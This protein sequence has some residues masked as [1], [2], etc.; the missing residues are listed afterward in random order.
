MP[1]RQA[2]GK[3]VKDGLRRCYDRGEGGLDEGFERGDAIEG[4]V[5]EIENVDVEGNEMNE[6]E[7][8]VEWNEEMWRWH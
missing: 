2:A 3:D 4:E 6:N 1:W 5:D 7:G 8:V